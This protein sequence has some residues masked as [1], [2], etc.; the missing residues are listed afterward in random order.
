MRI[1]ITGASGRLG[2]AVMRILPDAI[3]VNL[4]DGTQDLK[5]LF[6]DATHV[7]HLAAS[8]DFDDPSELWE[9]NY[10][11]TRRVVAALPENAH[12][13]YTS[14]ISVYGKVLAEIPADEQTKC[15][16]DTE[17]A[18]SK[19][20]AE[21]E[22]AARGNCVVLR[23]APIYGPEFTDYF[24]MFA[25]LEKNRMFIIRDGLNRVPFVHVDDVARAIKKS[26]NAKSGVY[27]ISG[28]ALTQE[29]LFAIACKWL[30][31]APPKRKLNKWIA[32][33]FFTLASFLGKLSGKKTFLTAEHIS[34]L[35]SDRAFDC[36]KARKGLGFRP[37][38]TEDGIREM[39]E[40]YMG[41][42]RRRG[43]H[44]AV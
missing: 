36:S 44:E 17:Y 10:E 7:I 34:V 32:A 30:G 33:I 9:G 12:M 39:A 6:R 2:K 41:D 35:S 23:I 19:H 43:S 21:K 22:V 42:L 24:K 1:Y 4:R 13:I 40:Y 11:L 16:P 27:V 20:A 38:K 5:A 8:L 25:M 28:N 15:N 18:R 29:E 31:I 3:P 14:S 37:R 26:L